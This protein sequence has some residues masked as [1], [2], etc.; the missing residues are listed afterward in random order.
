MEDER[1]IAMLWA[2]DE[3]AIAALQQ[4]YKAYCFAIAMRVL[5]DVQD[6]EEVLNDTWL[7]AWNS[8]PPYTPQ[9]LAAF[10]GKLTRNT[11]L[12]KYR[13]HTAQKR[14][15]AVTVSLEE[16]QECVPTEHTAEDLLQE[17]ELSGIIDR[18]LRAQPVHVRRIFVR[19]YWYFDSVSEIAARYNCSES[20]VKM[21]LLRTRAKLADYLKKEGVVE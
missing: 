4:K 13:T 9:K 17:R 2:R 5:C 8:I 20:R 16:L 19:R 12:K 6:A 14:S 7:A 1:I 10:V 18:F 21:I 15:N 11:A 3:N